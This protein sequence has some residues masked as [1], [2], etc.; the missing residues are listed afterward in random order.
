M[1]IIN[2]IMLIFFVS[3]STAFATEEKFTIK[4]LGHASFLI[5]SPGGVKIV[6]D[7]F[8]P[9]IGY[10][11]KHV[12]ADVITVS[13]EHY[14][15][16]YIKA[17]NGSPKVIRGLKE[18]G[19]DWNIVREKI[20]DVE[21]TNIGVF[22]DDSGGTRRGKNSIFILNISGL[23][24]VHLGDLGHI[25]SDQQVKS[26]GRV[27]ILFIPVGGNFTI[28]SKEA[29]KIVSLIKP[30]VIVPMHY[31]TSWVNLPIEP[32]DPFLKGKKNIIKLNGD[33]WIF[34]KKDIKKG[35]IVVFEY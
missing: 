5:V 25:L 6:T 31:R 21:I 34:T 30:S 22:H 4:Y 1:K 20:G 11:W 10:P 23:K 7:P 32:I 33:T 19:R 8:D 15:H 29:D 26:I 28:G 13:H 18:G 14:D 35:G 17:I 3:F 27:D 16:N 9:S 12:S 24:I 2:I